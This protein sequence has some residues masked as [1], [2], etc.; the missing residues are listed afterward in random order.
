MIEKKEYKEY[1]EQGI[2]TKSMLLDCL[3]SVN[4]RAKNYRD[5]ER[6]FRKVR[7]GSKHYRDVNNNEE[8]CREKK[9]YYYR[10]KKNLLTVLKPD[11]IHKELLNNGNTQYYLYYDAEG[12]SFHT[13]ISESE[14]EQ[15]QN[16]YH[17]QILVVPQ[18]KTYGHEV[19]GLVPADFCKQIEEL[20]L[21]GE[22]Q[23]INNP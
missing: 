8:K 11:F 6:K 10:Q 4:K 9:E 18:I 16:K 7:M 15:Y 1:L 5:E 2:I 20:V 21:S 19:G 13:P 3:Y 17:M 22:Y 23:Y 12:H 14:V